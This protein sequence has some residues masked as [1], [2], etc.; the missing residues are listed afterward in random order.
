MAQAQALDI[1]LVGR[2]L[3][4]N[5]NLGL[6]F[7]LAAA[8]QAELSS[9][10]LI[11]NSWVDLNRV[12]GEI[13]RRQ[14][15]LVGL[16]LPDGGSAALPLSLGELLRAAGYD[17]HIT[18]GGPFATLARYW[19]LDRYDW[20][21]SVVRHAGEVPLVGLARSLAKASTSLT[22]VPGLTTRL[23][24]GTPA[25]VL[26]PHQLELEPEHGQLPEVLGHPMVHIL[27]TRGCRGRCAYCG[28]AALQ[29][30]EHEEGRRAGH[31][32]KTLTCAGVG[33]QRR[34]SVDTLCDEMASL[35]HEQG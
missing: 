27:A 16:A 10:R 19:L 4:D 13:V 7:L 5:E 6:G 8:R 3:V 34:R 9:E 28:P 24:D 21:D 26:D 18:A 12:A 23:G 15:R 22:S 25:A 35:W 29:R 32:R 1:V 14:P 33:G 31:D 20:L 30:L 17:G 11:L 2:Q